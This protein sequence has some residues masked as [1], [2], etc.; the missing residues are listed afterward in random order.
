MISILLT[1]YNGQPYI[2]DL[3]ESL[4]KQTVKD[5]RLFIRDD[6]STDSTFSII[7]GYAK[8]YP[9]K[10]TVKQ[11]EKNTGGSKQNF[12]QMMIDYKDDYVMLCDQDDV[13]LQGKIEKNL[14]KMK[15]MEN[16]H[17]MT[18][19]ILVHTDLKVVDENLKI[20]SS[21]YR[22]MANIGY[23]FNKLNNLAA[24]NIPTGCTIMYNRALAELI[25]VQ[26]G[27]IVMHDWWVSLIAAAFGKIGSI[28]EQTVLYRQHR[29][30]DIGAKKALSLRY[31]KYVLTHISIMAGKLNNSYKQAESFLRV[32][33]DKLSDEQ[34]ELLTAHATMQ[35]QTKTGKLRTMLKY[36]TF[37]YGIARK[38]GQII[39]ILSSS[40]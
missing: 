31:I 13:W 11:N 6:S 4:L 37:L 5:F 38:A 39:V 2:A 22:R 18:T 27:F 23:K 3:L 19:P 21:S 1:T 32:F 9:D 10:I 28:K 26:P 12:I 24:M 34:K 15:E 35:R 16:T 30:N 17:G 14:E 36:N 29:A 33:Y 7:T 25:N 8:R 40:T 20:I